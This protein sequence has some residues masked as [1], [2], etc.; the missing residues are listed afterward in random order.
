M[1]TPLGGPV[2]QL[3]FLETFLSTL[4]GG[5]FAALIFFYTSDFFMRREKVKR[6]KKIN[7]ALLSGKTIKR[8]KVFTKFNKIIV[9]IKSTIGIYMICWL[10]PLFLS[11]PLGTIICAKFYKHDKRTV[12]LIL[13]GL[14]I[15]CFLITS[16]VYTLKMAVI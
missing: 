12:W 8:K 3:S 5:Y 6:I 11:V 2:A 1:F 9:R 16:L 14:T 10:V 4:S 13:A 7:K 15:N